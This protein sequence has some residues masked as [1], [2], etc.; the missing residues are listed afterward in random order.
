MGSSLPLLSHLVLL[1][2]PYWVRVPVWARWGGTVLL[3]LGGVHRQ[4]SGLKGES[5]ASLCLSSREGTDLS[6]HLGLEA[7]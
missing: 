2:K 5:R 4:G 3:P 6:G 7:L 1:E